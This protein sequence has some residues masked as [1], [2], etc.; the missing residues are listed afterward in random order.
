[1]ETKG[2]EKKEI[3]SI[4][5]YSKKIRKSKLNRS[6]DNCPSLKTHIHKTEQH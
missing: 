5:N 4:E 2:T 3:T 6:A 1:M